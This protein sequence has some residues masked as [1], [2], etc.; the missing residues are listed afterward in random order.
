MTNSH[1]THADAVTVTDAGTDTV[2]DTGTATGTVA[3]ADT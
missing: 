1:H 2:A 3:V